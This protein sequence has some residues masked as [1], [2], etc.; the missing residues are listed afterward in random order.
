MDG[1]GMETNQR[2]AR[3]TLKHP[4]PG[5]RSLRRANHDAA[6]EAI[7]SNESAVGNGVGDLLLAADAARLSGHPK[8]ALT[9]I[10]RVLHD[11]PK[12]PRAPSAAYTLGKIYLQTKDNSR[13]A[14][15]FAK[16]RALAPEGPLA[17]DALAREVQAWSRASDNAKARARAEEY[18]RL[19][20]NGD[21]IQSVKRQRW[22]RIE[23]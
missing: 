20:P 13:A 7:Q 3:E 16:A 8:A 17:S 19:Y 15:L 18:V 5:R 1:L 4:P 6:F 14:E 22:P 21:Q 23:P 9:Y 11:H 2:G 12:D 10:E